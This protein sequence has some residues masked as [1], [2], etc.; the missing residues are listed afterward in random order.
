MKEYLDLI[1][2]EKWRK[3]CGFTTFI[4]AIEKLRSTKEIN[5]VLFQGNDF[6]SVY[7][8]FFYNHCAL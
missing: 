6:I 4:V 2:E 5:I 3:Q 7:K 1:I 8:T